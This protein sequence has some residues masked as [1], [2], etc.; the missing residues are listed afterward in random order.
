LRHKVGANRVVAIGSLGTAVALVLFGLARVPAAALAASLL[1][2]ISWLSA[3]ATLNVSA[4]FSI[5]NWVRG[6]GLA[7]YVTAFYGSMTVGSVVWGQLAGTLGLP[8][9]HFV[10]AAGALLA[11]PL[12]WRWKLQSGAGSDLAPSMHWQAPIIADDVEDDRGPV[13]VT[14]EYVVREADREAFL[15]AIYKLARERRRDGAYAWETLEDVA[16]PGRFLE[17]FRLESWLEHLY[18]HERVTKADRDLQALVNA[19]HHDGIPKVTHFISARP[20]GG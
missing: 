1:A 17:T 13:E 8:V 6:R 10:A 14:V 18:Q 15:L 5:P 12:S 20:R 11:I 7:I 2:G 19:F 16:Q 4:Q 9:T 3:L